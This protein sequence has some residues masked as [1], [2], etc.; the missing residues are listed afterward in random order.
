MIENENS[1]IE[2]PEYPDQQRALEEWHRT[3]MHDLERVVRKR[4]TELVFG[5][6]EQDVKG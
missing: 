4:I 1:L 6:L 5:I 2:Q 3:F